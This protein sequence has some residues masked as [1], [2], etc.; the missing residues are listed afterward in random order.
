MNN[1]D[2]IIVA[3]DTPD[4]DRA[5]KLVRMLKHKISFFKVGLELFCFAG[6]NII[7]Q[8]TQEGCKV[9][10]DLKFHDIPNTAAG[11]VRS[12]VNTGAT[13]LNVH[14]FGGKKMMAAAKKAADE[15]YKNSKGEKPKV[16]AVTV[17]TSFS[18]EDLQELNVSKPTQ[19]QVVHLAKLAKESGL[20]GVVASPLEIE[21]IREAIGKDFLIVTPGVRPKWAAKGDQKRVMTPKQALEKGADFIVIGR[22]ITAAEDPKVALDKIFQD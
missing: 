12:S 20:D 10:L 14:A 22:P 15:A 5:L 4:E 16:L 6:P 17:L 3:L 1:Y 11:A 19:D 8:I 21:D 18:E 9:F 2:K 7:K 13:L